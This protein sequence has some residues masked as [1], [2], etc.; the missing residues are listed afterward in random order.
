MDET[1]NRCRK[2]NEYLAAFRTITSIASKCK[3]V[4]FKLLSVIRSKNVPELFRSP[5]HQTLIEIYCSFIK[6]TI[7]S[8]VNSDEVYTVMF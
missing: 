4:L 7:N 2:S 8:A 6:V 3:S 5:K 1:S